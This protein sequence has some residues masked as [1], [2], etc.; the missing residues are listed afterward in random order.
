MT[1]RKALPLERRDINGES[2]ELTG[3][4]KIRG[5]AIP[6]NSWT[7]IGAGPMSFRERVAPGA[8]SKTL[9]EMDTVYL[10]NHDPAKPIA[11]K[12]AGTLVVTVTDRGAEYVAEP[13]DTSYGRDLVTNIR[14]KNILGNSFGFEPV[15]D[16]W[17]LGDDGVEERTILEMKLPEISACT[18]PAYGDTDIGMRTAYETAMEYRNATRAAK[19]T[20]ADLN[21][22]G[23]CGATGQYGAYCGA[24]GAAM[25]DA[26]ANPNDYCT[27]CGAQLDDSTRASH[28]CEERADS[29]TPYGDV[30]YADPKNGKYPINNKEH[31]KAAWSYINM[32][33]NAEKYPLNGVTLS[34]VKA[35]IKAALK[36]FGVTVSEKNSVDFDDID[37]RNYDPERGFV[38]T[39][40]DPGGD[41]IAA[42]RAAIAHLNDNDPGAAREALEA[43]L[44]TSD[45]LEPDDTDADDEG[46]GGGMAAHTNPGGAA[47]DLARAAINEAYE[48]VRALAPTRATQKILAILE[49]HLSTPDDEQRGEPKPDASTSEIAAVSDSGIELQKRWLDTQREYR[50]LSR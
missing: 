31:A 46:E 21:T 17:E 24:C 34:S 28:V 12:S 40:D 14:A 26:D 11:R 43:C 50:S 15:K 16:K 22:C 25:G 7:T 2:P 13:A 10:D 38:E 9:R 32:P 44:E 6:F 5:L 42:M 49:P 45:S 37:L 36:E 23:E 33:K 4:G 20:Y 1:S 48:E 3:D 18:F 8:I 41:E 35:K 39:R 27:S 47:V 30:K 29:K 19:A